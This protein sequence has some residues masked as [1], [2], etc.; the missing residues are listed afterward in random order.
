MLAGGAAAFD[1][2]RALEERVTS[3]GS[4]GVELILGVRPEAVLVS[5]EAAAGHIP[6][7]AHIIEPLGAYDIVDLRIGGEFL[8]A[9]TASGFVGKPGD[10]VWAKLDEAQTHFFDSASGNAI[11]VRLG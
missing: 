1:F 11:D 10:T 8:R 7:E 5:R 2:P 6:V 9:R 3:V 4:S